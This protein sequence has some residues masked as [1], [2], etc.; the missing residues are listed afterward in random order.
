MTIFG[1]HI[2]KTDTY[3]FKIKLPANTGEQVIIYL[4]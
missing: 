3:L 4:N 2:Q 1:I